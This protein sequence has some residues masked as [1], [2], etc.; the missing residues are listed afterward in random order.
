MLKYAPVK[1]GKK[2]FFETGVGI[3]EG[4]AISGGDDNSTYYFSAQHLDK[5][6][7]TPRDEYVRNNFRLNVSRNHGRLKSTTSVSF[8]E[9]KTNVAGT[10]PNAGTVYRILLNSPSHINLSDYKNWRTDKFST[11]DTYYNA[12]F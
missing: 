5:T 4:I 6:G 9:D 12:Y 10:D 1:N 3:Q 11:P 2:N 8:F 7:V